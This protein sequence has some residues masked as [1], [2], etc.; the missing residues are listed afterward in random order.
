[1][2]MLAIT[3]RPGLED[4]GLWCGNLG[5]SVAVVVLGHT[6]HSNDAAG[7]VVVMQAIV[8]LVPFSVMTIRATQETPFRPPGATNLQE[9]LEAYGYPSWFCPVFRLAKSCTAL[10]VAAGILWTPALLVGVGGIL[11]FMICAVGSHIKVRDPVQKSVPSGTLVLMCIVILLAHF[12][13]WLEGNND[14]FCANEGFRPP[15][16]FATTSARRSIVVVIL[17]LCLM[18]VAHMGASAAGAISTKEK[19][20]PLL[21]A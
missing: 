6:G 11:V 13:G 20:A 2:S 9:E 5:M 10:A 15:A 19:N 8:A 7:I 4:V 16:V 17:G 18:M 3:I 21:S 14:A 1:M 12:E